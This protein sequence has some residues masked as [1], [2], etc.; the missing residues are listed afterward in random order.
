MFD[1]NIW[2]MILKLV[3]SLVLS[4][5]IGFERETHDRPAGLRTHILVS[6]GSTLITLC[7]YSISQSV[8]GVIFDPGRVTAQIV[9][10]V[11]FLGAGTIIHQG[12]MV[13]GLTTAASIWTVAG[14]GIAVGIGGDMFYLALA[15]SVLVFATLT[16]V[17]NIEQNVLSRHVERF[18]SITVPAD[19]ESLDRALALFSQHD[20]RLRV[21]SSR[22]SVDDSTQ[23][24]RLGLRPG[25]NFDQLLLSTELAASKDVMSYIWE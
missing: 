22:M 8:A 24:M 2:S 19:R 16:T 7:S 12:S 13:R 20:V 11:G 3:I 9:T 17:R 6:V 1:A 10:G 14:I 15:A 23:I 5:L 25:R 21:L 18:I 4:G